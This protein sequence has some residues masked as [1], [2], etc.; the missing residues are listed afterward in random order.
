MNQRP[1]NAM[2]GLSA[3]NPLT[4]IDNGNGGNV[5]NTHE[6][7]IGGQSFNATSNTIQTLERESA[8]NGGGPDRTRAWM[9]AMNHAV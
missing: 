5:P 1:G 4:A 3:L 8:L 6:R 9:K 2:H 7:S